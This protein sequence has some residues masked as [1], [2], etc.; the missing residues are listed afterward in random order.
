MMAGRLSVVIVA[1]LY[2]KIDLVI[3]RRAAAES[4]APLGSTQ[5]IPW[6]VVRTRKDLLAVGFILQDNSQ[7]RT[8]FCCFQNIII[9]VAFRVQNKGFKFFIDLEH[10]GR[11][12]NAIVVSFAFILIDDDFHF[13]SASTLAV[14]PM[15]I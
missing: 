7:L 10:V 13:S 3:F 4:T 1:G 12:R 11:N 15:N 9:A 2:Q 5:L 14:I 8:S 6:F